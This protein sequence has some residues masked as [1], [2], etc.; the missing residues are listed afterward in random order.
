MYRIRVIKDKTGHFGNG[1]IVDA[2]DLVNLYATQTGE[3]TRE[4]LDM[5]MYEVVSHISKTLGIRVAVATD[6]GNHK[7]C[8]ISL[9]IRGHDTEERICEAEKA[10]WRAAKLLGFKNPMELLNIST[11]FEINC[12][13]SLD[14]YSR[15]TGNDIEAVLDSDTVYFCKGWQNSKRCRAEY[16]V[17][18]IYGKELFFE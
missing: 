10:R 6:N 15:Q 18:Q 1:D 11:T 13:L 16:E 4:L 8:F 12:H 17:A 9:P 3:E 14:E 2:N 5:P 7:T